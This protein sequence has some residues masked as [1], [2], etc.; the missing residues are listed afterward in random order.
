MR[1]KNEICQ[2]ESTLEEDRPWI[3]FELPENSSQNWELVDDIFRDRATVEGPLPVEVRVNHP[4][5]LEWDYYSI[6]GTSGAF[7]HRAWLLLSPVARTHFSF[8]ELRLNKV[9]YYLF[10]PT[11]PL[12][13]LDLGTSELVY[14]SH[15]P[16]RIREVKKFRFK[17][18]SFPNPV[19]FWIPECW[20]KILCTASVRDLVMRECLRGLKFVGVE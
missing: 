11:I 13:C 1:D 19:V 10:K 20:S 8:Y 4:E 3:D 18:D 16:S 12:H 14:Y 5:A 2:I 17:A 15:D 6:P 9:E 7:S